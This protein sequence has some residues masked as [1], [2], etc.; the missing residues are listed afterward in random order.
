MRPGRPLHTHTHT[1][2]FPQQYQK[3]Y[4]SWFRLELNTIRY[5]SKKK[6]EDKIVSL[7]E[8]SSDHLKFKTKEKD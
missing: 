7:N 3:E 5:I 4:V 6:Y 2:I 8:K 1:H